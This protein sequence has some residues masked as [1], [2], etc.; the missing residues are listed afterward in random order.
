MPE[1][2]EHYIKNTAGGSNGRCFDILKENYDK[3]K[4][5]FEEAI[6]KGQEDLVTPEN[7]IN[8]IKN[9]LY[10]LQQTGKTIK[11]IVTDAEEMCENAMKS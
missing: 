2:L 1:H 3:A 6:R 5:L 4:T 7:I 11:G 10:E 9:H 8:E